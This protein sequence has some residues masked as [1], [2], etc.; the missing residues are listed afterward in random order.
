MIIAAGALIVLGGGAAWA[1]FI[2][3]GAK[4]TKATAV[5][6]AK[7]AVFLDVPEVLVNLS[8]SGGERTQYL[9][10]KIV[11]ELADGGR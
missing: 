1:Y 3:G 10:V 4:E 9:K 11:L 6:T 8:N 2:F 5:V 7:P